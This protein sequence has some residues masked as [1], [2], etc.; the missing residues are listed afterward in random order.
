MS[1][2]KRKPLALI[3]K[4]SDADII[5]A[6]K[7]QNFDVILLPA[8]NRLAYQ[9]SSH[10]DMLIF[11]VDGTV[12]CNEEYYQKYTSIFDLIKN[13]GYEINRSKFDVSAEYP[14]DVALNQAVV[15]KNIFG[16]EK[17]C[18]KSILR[19]AKSQG[20]IYHPIKQGYA[21]C[22]TLILGDKAVI[23]ADLGIIKL[24]KKLGVNTLQIKN[25]I[26]EIRLDGY[27]YGFIGGASA[28]YG[29][30]VF[31]FGDI[32]LHSQ[33]K[34]IKEFCHSNGFTAI[35]LTDKTLCDIGG[36]IILPDINE[37]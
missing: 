19:Y 8:D 20:Y 2:L 26:D 10:A 22:S 33:G 17:S 29:D 3:G 12:F 30:K 23:S 7:N 15:K 9:V 21:K 14:N 4:N 18:A 1:I 11:T 16:Y 13:H 32:L 34:E 24:A 28:V 27:N 35:S 25:S 5:P 36:A 31:F 6:L 37:K